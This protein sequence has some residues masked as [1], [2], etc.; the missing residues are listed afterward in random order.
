M[1]AKVSVM[2]IT[3]LI[4]GLVSLSGGVLIFY[5]KDLQHAMKINAF[6]GSIGPFVFMGLSL[7]GVAGLAGQVEI[8]KIAMLC[9]GV[10][11]IMLG[12]R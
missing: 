1:D 11:L 12:A 4:Y 3:R 9:V 5:F 2:A 6:L 7:V 8:K 10:I